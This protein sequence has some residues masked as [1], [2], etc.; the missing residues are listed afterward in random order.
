MKNHAAALW[1]RSVA[2]RAPIA[3]RGNSVS[4]IVEAVRSGVGLAPLPFPYAK[5]ESEPS[6]CWRAAR[7]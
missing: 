7:S 3:A 5:R 2:P 1:L 6:W 4:E